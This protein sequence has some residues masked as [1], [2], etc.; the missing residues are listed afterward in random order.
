MTYESVIEK[1]REIPEEYMD[2]VAVMVD[3]FRIVR[4][5]EN[6]GFRVEKDDS[7]IVPA[8]RK[9]G[10]TLSMAGKMHIDGEFV[11]SMRKSLWN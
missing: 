4:I 6:R 5:P 3:N 8:K 1:I 9:M 7:I 10:K 2:E 11:K